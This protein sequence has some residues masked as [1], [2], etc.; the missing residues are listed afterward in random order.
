ML[1]ARAADGLAPANCH[2]RRLAA[3]QS[4]RAW[5]LG[6][7]RPAFHVG[8]LFRAMSGA[9]PLLTWLVLSGL[10]DQPTPATVTFPV[11]CSVALD[12]TGKA[13]ASEEWLNGELGAAQNLF[14]P[15]GVAFASTPG[16]SLDA[17]AAHVETRADR[18]GLAPHVVPHVI[19]VFVV[20]SIRDV[21]DPAQMRR[22]VHWHAPTGAHYIILVASAP[23]TV[24]AHELGH[25][26]GNPHRH[27]VDNVMS[28]ERSGGH[29]FFDADQGKRIV[30]R[31]AAYVRSGELLPVTR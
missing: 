27:M 2:T 7:L 3:A 21:D 17:A 25:Y 16:V 15:F 23:T 11:R 22:G 31:A 4:L 28:Y 13:V 9:L 29:V 12:P 10:L 1:G 6:G 18:D 20:D 30:S 14:A 26:F 5:L 8:L 24:L 19:D